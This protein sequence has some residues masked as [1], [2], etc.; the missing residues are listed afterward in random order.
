MFTPLK[1]WLEYLKQRLALS[2]PGTFP[3]WFFF[4]LL[5]RA[6]VAGEPVSGVGPARCP[7]S[8]GP[9]S[10]PAPHNGARSPGRPRR[11]RPG[12]GAGSPG[13]PSGS[14]PRRR[15]GRPSR[16]GLRA[17]GGAEAA[18]RGL[19][20]A[21][22]VRAGGK[23]RVARARPRSLGERLDPPAPGRRGPRGE[24]GRPRRRPGTPGRPLPPRARAAAVAADL[25]E[26]LS[27][28]PLHLILTQIYR[29][30]TGKPIPAL[31]TPQLVKKKKHRI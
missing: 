18:A 10:P 6:C 9:T 20:R 28:L 15:L 2:F 8:P 13:T 31:P 7:A 24:R 21:I 30:N 27:W 17:G 14:G 25:T 22:P 11:R 12:R 1:Q 19:G 29:H 26:S 23:L 16:P 4:F 3:V 5:Q